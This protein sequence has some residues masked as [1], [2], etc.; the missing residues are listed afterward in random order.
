[1][2]TTVSPSR[3]KIRR[4]TAAGCVAGA[5]SRTIKPLIQNKSIVH[6]EL[7]SNKPPIQSEKAEVIMNFSHVPI[8]Q[9]HQTN[10][11]RRNI[12]ITIGM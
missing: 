10:L 8:Y 6:K 2:I 7:V 4:K 5:K 1:M 11:S 3:M 12:K 9:S